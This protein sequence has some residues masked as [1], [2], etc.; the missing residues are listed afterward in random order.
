[1]RSTTTPSPMHRLAVLIGSSPEM[2]AIRDLIDRLANAD[3]SV[4]VTGP[5]GS[6][7]E[8]V[9]ELLHQRGGRAARPFV[10]VNCV[11]GPS[12]LLESDLFGHAAGAFTGAVHA[13]S[14]KFEL[15]DGGTLF[16]D[17]IGD[18]PPQFQAKLLRVLET[19]QVERVGGTGAV[20]I[21]VRVV[22]ATN[23]DLPA[24]IAAGRFRADLFYRLAVV[25]IALP[26]LAAR[27]E[28]ISALVAHF[29]DSAGH[30][31]RLRFTASALAYLTE[32][33]W[34]GN[35]REVRN[36]VARAAAIH[37]AIE[38]D[39]AAAAVLLH[40]ERRSVDRWLA[41]DG[42]PVPLPNRRRPPPLVAAEPVDLKAL[43]TDFEQS[44]IRDA[45]GRTAFGVAASARLLGMPRTTL[46]EKMRRYN[47]GRPDV[48]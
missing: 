6:G 29:A 48:V 3:A 7:K 28:D 31:Q 40:G 39:E 45:L 33:P 32:Q 41:T 16:L 13:R 1:M 42:S 43:L 44:V 2:I 25:E 10:A 26:P 23:V 34:P 18:M 37:G 5:S 46:V 4:L 36:F 22:A 47:I 8:V 14:G 35:V 20:A 9:A 19:R 38:I 27:R 24:A 17:E 21:D 12:D 30:G 11:A 15:A